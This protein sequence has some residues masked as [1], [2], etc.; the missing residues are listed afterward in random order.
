MAYKLLYKKQAIE[1]AKRLQQYEPQAFKK[2]LKLESELKV[3]PQSGTGHPEKLKGFDG[4]R[5]SRRISQKHRLVYDIQDT[6]VTVV[7]LMA[8]GHYDDK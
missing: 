1:D 8:F 6:E 3:H 4:N 2:L 7:V 5:W